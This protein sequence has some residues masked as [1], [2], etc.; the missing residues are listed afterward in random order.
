MSQLREINANLSQRNKQLTAQM[1]FSESERRE[2][3][4]QLSSS[5]NAITDRESDVSYLKK[6]NQSLRERVNKLENEKKRLERSYS[7]IEKEKSVLKTTLDDIQRKTSKTYETSGK[8]DMILDEA[9]IIT[10]GLAALELKNIELQRKVQGLQSIMNEAE[11]M[12]GSDSVHQPNGDISNPS[13]DSDKLLMAQKH[14]E[15]LIDSKDLSINHLSNWIS[16]TY[17]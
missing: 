11:N 10:Q 8:N 9:K 14:A 2:F 12:N 13:K 5:C 7:L 15:H 4:R 6:D 16:H 3:E 17:I 1:S